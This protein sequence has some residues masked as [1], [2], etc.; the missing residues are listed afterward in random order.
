MKLL[1]S[2]GTVCMADA[3]SVVLQ[4]CALRRLH[5]LLVTWDEPIKMPQV[6]DVSL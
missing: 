3:S 1:S 2:R 6:Q 4:T 5:T